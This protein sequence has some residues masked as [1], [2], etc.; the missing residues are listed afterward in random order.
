MRSS[1]KKGRGKLGPLAPLLGSWIAVNDKPMPMSC[2][3][4]YAPFG[5]K[6]VKLEA[7]WMFSAPKASAKLNDAQRAAM[8][9]Y[10]GKT[11]REIAFFG[12][13]KSGALA[14][15]SFTN[16]GKQ[17]EGKLAAASDIHP[18]AICFEAQMDAGLARQIFWPDAEEGFHWAVESRTKKGW[19]RFTEHHYR[20]T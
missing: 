3:R 6:Y 2:T 4:I 11:Y 18:A 10:A 13:D 20:P 14:F 8:Q 19:N 17:A 15:W 5:E 16:D 12:L 9:A 7:Q 1:W